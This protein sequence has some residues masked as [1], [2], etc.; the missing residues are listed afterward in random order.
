ML[1]ATV[2][3]VV[4]LVVAG[5]FVAAFRER[6][7]IHAE[8]T[9]FVAGLDARTQ[10]EE[11]DGDTP[12]GGERT[13]VPEDLGVLLEEALQTNQHGLA[14]LAVS[15]ITGR[16]RLARTR[17]RTLSRG[18][19][20]I[21]LLSGGGGAFAVAALGSFEREALIQA[22]ASVATG[23][24]GSLLSGSQSGRSLAHSK[25]YVELTD[26][27]AAQVARHFREEAEGD[28]R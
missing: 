4:F 22:V 12:L 15:E 18:L 23:V 3:V 19:S 11:G 5:C 21:S 17:A 27:L 2:L 14:V 28:G 26:V 1:S 16:A 24:V 9:A 25:R 20:R 10:P 13:S 8:V 6:S 7:R